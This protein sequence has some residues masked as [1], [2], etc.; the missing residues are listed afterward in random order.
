MRI[1]SIRV[2]IGRC[3]GWITAICT[4]MSHIDHFHTIY[5]AQK[6]DGAG[7]AM[8]LRRVLRIPEKRGK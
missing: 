1:E 2:R 6:V 5:V 4:K 8:P 7:G 3:E